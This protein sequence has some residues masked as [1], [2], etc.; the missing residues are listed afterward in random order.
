MRTKQIVFDAMLV[1]LNFILSL[2]AISLSNMKISL[3]A[4]PILTGA[5]LFGPWDGLTIG[6]LGSFLNQLL[7]Y[8]ITPTTPVWVLPYAV[9]G[10]AVGLY[11]K[12][13][14]FSLSFRQ[15]IFIT[16]LSALVVTALNTLA[17]YVDSKLYGYYSVPY[18][19]GALT[20]RVLSGVITSIAFSILLPPLLKAL[21]SQVLARKAGGTSL[22]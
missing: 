7:A 13:K 20:F 1:A 10:L 12:A 4:L 14:G 16:I 21:R 2:I 8:G 22:R 19:F 17:M 5:M 18:V 9:S 6:L 3:A 11:A 15:T